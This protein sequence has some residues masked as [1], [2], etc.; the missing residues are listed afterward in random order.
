MVGTMRFLGQRAVVVGS[1]TLFGL[2][3]LLGLAWWA[4]LLQK[5]PQVA[6]PH[7]AVPFLAAFAL[8]QLTAWLLTA[9]ALRWVH[10]S[11]SEGSVAG[12]LLVSVG[13]VAGNLLYYFTP[14]VGAPL[15][16]VVGLVAAVLL[17][18]VGRRRVV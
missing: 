4:V 16:A 17:F 14:V 5:R 15:L 18:A 13:L 9:P 7:E 10:R 12:L 3:V 8:V 2:S 11:P 6:V 1:E